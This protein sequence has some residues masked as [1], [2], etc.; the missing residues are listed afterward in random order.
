MEKD[1]T[2]LTPEEMMLQEYRE[3]VDVISRHCQMLTIEQTTPAQSLGAIFKQLSVDKATD[4]IESDLRERGEMEEIE[5]IIKRFESDEQYHHSGSVSYKVKQLL[6]TYQNR[7]AQAIADKKSL[8]DDCVIYFRSIAMLIESASMGT[9]HRDKEARL[10]GLIELV[11]NTLQKF[12][13][14]QT[15]QLL[16]STRYFSFN[17][18]DYPYRAALRRLRRENAELREQTGQKSLAEDE[19]DAF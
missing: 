14:G 2:S 8:M 1:N 18:S 9:T 5:K 3:I 13:N 17:M 10:S 19:T 15:D 12:Q 11:E 16:N 7:T 4:Q 6:G